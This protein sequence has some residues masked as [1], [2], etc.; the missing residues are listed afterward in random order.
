MEKGQGILGFAAI[1]QV[2]VVVLD[3]THINMEVVQF[4]DFID[5]GLDVSDYFRLL[6]ERMGQGDGADAKRVFP[7]FVA[8]LQVTVLAEGIDEAGYRRFV[9]PQNT[10]NLAEA[11]A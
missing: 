8:L 4:V 7:S 6:Q 9:D 2:D 5:I 3:E 10:G 11:V 1:D